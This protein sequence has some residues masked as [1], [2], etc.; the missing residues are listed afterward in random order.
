DG[1]SVL[2]SVVL[3]A[4]ALYALAN[5]W[6]W[7][8]DVWTTHISRGFW[9]GLIASEIFNLWLNFR[10]RR[11]AAP[12]PEFQPQRSPRLSLR[13]SR[14]IK[15]IEDIEGRGLDADDLAGLLAR[16]LGGN[17]YTSPHAS[18]VLEHNGAAPQIVYV[19]DENGRLVEIEL[20]SRER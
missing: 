6:F 1:R 19:R 20:P 15:V 11:H 18:P 4:L 13:R 12:V 16:H 3:L 10:G 7:V 17:T 5:H 9:P 2:V 8:G 14:T